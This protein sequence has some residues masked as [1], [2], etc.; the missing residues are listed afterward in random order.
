MGLKFKFFSFLSILCNSSFCFSPIIIGVGKASY[1]FMW[2]T[3]KVSI[4]KSSKFNVWPLYL[5]INALLY[6]ERF[7]KEKVY[8]VGL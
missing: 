8:L 5:I 1:A 2:N 7:K 4:F 3:D 6:V